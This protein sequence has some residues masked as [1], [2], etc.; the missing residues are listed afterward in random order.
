MWVNLNFRLKVSLLYDDKWKSKFGTKW[1]SK[2]NK[3]M[4]LA[5]PW[6]QQPSLDVKIEI[7]VVETKYIPG[8]FKTGGPK[9][10]NYIIYL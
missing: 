4:N 1:W 10:N 7:D 6:F 9:Y 2:I 5:K 3:V 8:D